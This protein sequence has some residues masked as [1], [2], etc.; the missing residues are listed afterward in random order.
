MMCC[1]ARP[2]LSRGVSFQSSSSCLLVVK[3]GSLPLPLFAPFSSCLSSGNFPLLLGHSEAPKTKCKHSCTLRQWVLTGGGFAPQGTRG[4]FGGIFWL[5]QLEGWGLLASGGR[6][7]GM[8]LNVPR[9]TGCPATENR[10]CQSTPHGRAA[11][12]YCHT[13][14]FTFPLGREQRPPQKDHCWDSW[15]GR[16]TDNEYPHV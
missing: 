15:Q 11:N 7:P 13:Q 9:C 6:R 8:L 5:S 14:V 3:M 2:F 16:C 12:P 10:P 1:F 4:R